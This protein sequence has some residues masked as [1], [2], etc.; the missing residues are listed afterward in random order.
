MNDTLHRT[1]ELLWLDRAGAL[2]AQESRE[3]AALL[4]ALDP[5]ARASLEREV[6]GEFA[7]M[8]QAMAATDVTSEEAAP[9]ALV[10]ALK[11][12]VPADRP[13]DRS[14]DGDATPLRFERRTPENAS[15]PRSGPS[16]LGSIG[17]AAAAALA[18]VVILQSR[19]RTPVTPAPPTVQSRVDAATDVVRIP[20]AANDPSA[21]NATGLVVWS[22]SLQLG[23]LD[24]RGFPA[25]DRT[26]EQYQLWIVDPSR[27]EQ[28]ID[29]GVFD[30]AAGTQII[31]FAP[32][33]PVTAPQVFAVTAEKPGG[34]VVT[35]GPMLLVGKP[36]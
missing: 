23:Y 14:T 25:N 12:A 11:S 8:D 7:A 22:P 3:L 1:R 17:W 13:A 5:T 21:N 34:V 26:K 10:A 29:A 27:A 36:S 4:A 32:K 19:G 2:D 28:P 35:D 24:L 6:A 33:L 9:A 30:V 20:L 18:V 31:P 16:L 15:R